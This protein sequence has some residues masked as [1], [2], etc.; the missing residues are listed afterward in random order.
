MSNTCGVCGSTE[1]EAIADA[2]AIGLQEEFEHG[3]YTC[4]QV[5]E[6]AYEQA[7]AWFE[8]TDEDS[9][10]AGPEGVRSELREAQPVYVYVRSR[11]SQVPWYRKP[12]GRF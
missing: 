3:V 12:D 6:W 1:S 4:C 9:Q 8:A 10:R 5:A 7:V 11:R 2:K